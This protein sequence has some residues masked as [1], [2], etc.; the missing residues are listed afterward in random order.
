MKEEMT[1]NLFN[2]RVNEASV[3]AARTHGDQLLAETEANPDT[4][5]SSAFSALTIEELKKI[6][7]AVSGTNVLFKFKTIKNV[8]M[9]QD[10]VNMNLLKESA[11]AADSHMLAVV[12]FAIMSEFGSEQGSAIQWTTVSSKILRIIGNKERQAGASAALAAQAA[13]I[14]TGP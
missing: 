7:A 11:E 6:H 3:V 14:G 12:K 10:C 8:L 1:R 2:I 5:M 4:I 9:R 13:A